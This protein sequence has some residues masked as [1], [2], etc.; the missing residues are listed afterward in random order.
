[1]TLAVPAPGE[2][3]GLALQL[4]GPVSL[5]LFGKVDVFRGDG[6]I[7]NAFAGIPDVPL[8]RFEL[9]FTTASPLKLKRD[10]CHGKRQTVT[11]KLTGHN[12]K[13]ANLRAPL[14]VAGCP[15]VV[16]LKRGSIRVKPGR[17]GA[18]IRTVK[19]AGKRVK[20]SQR[21]RLRAGKRYR[22]TVVDRGKETWKLTVR[23]RR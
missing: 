12:G 6:L 16:T 9:S 17:D 23:V 22:V 7:H 10:V 21:V 13:V 2:L 3:P 18:K 15:P 11:G 20:T 14:K 1:M 19:L 4:T 5:P 8:E